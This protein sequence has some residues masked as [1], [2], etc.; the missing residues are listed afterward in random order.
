MKIS[1]S[2]ADSRAFLEADAF[3]LL[4]VGCLYF[5]RVTGSLV[6]LH[7]WHMGSTVLNAFFRTFLGQSAHQSWHPLA[8]K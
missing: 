6:L 2:Y 7:R 5:P 3:E 4:E 1:M 8:C